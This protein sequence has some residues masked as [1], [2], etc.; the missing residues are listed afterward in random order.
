MSASPEEIARLVD[1]LDHPDAIFQRQMMDKILAIGPAA[2]EP[3]AAN[4][5]FAEPRAKEAIA[6]LLGELRD[7]RAMLPLMRFIFDARGS[8][9][10]SDARGLAMQSLMHLAEPEHAQKLF[11]FLMDIRRDPDPFV[12]G[13]AMEAMGKFGDKRA[14]PILEEALEDDHEFVQTRAQRAVAALDAD[15][16]VGEGLRSGASA[17]EIL[18]KIR[19]T[20]GGERTYWINALKER[21]DAF[22]LARTLVEEGGKGTLIGLQLLLRMNDPRAREVAVR[23]Y[24]AADAA[25]DRAI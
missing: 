10:D 4:L 3:L 12:R 11:D 17:T 13:Y 2:V 16:A 14:R 24:A 1:R 15:T 25:A 8:I 6:R 22:E 7:T 20:Q 21:D 18:Q 23:H 9:P 19:A 5:S